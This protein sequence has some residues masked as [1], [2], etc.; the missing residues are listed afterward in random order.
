MINNVASNINEKNLAVQKVLQK[1]VE[2]T[3]TCSYI[4][5]KRMA[6]ENRNHIKHM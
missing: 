5:K 4:E 2:S 1:Y 3:Q 6:L